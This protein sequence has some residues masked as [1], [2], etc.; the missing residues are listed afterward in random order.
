MVAGIPFMWND[1]G[2]DGYLHASM[3]RALGLHA[4]VNINCGYRGKRVHRLHAM[5]WT[6]SFVKTQ[7]SPKTTSNMGTEGV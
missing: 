7:V 6:T 1:H 5:A 2:L 4:L 3:R